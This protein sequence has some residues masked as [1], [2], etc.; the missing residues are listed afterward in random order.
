MAHDRGNP[1]PPRVWR[2]ALYVARKLV[3]QYRLGSS[4]RPGMH[5]Q[6]SNATRCSKRMLDVQDIAV[7]R[8]T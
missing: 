2:M 5:R 8:H 3:V 6:P 4:E 1:L 7:V